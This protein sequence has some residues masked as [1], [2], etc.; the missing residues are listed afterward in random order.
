MANA[1]LQTRDLIKRYGSTTALAG[2]NLTV[3]QGEFIALLGPSGCGKTTLLR[4]IAGFIEPST[5]SINIDGKDITGVPPHHRPVNTVFQNYALFPHMTVRANVGYGP[6]RHGIAKSEIPKRVDDALEMV[7]MEAFADRFP[8]QLSGGQQQRVA[9]ARAIINRPRVLLLD[10][11]L[12][13]L[14]LKLRKR[15]QI[16][17]KSLQKRLGTTFI[18]VTHDQ[19]EAL[20]MADRIAVMRDGH[21]EQIGSGDA[22][23]N[24]PESLFVADFI[25]EANLIDV[26]V[27]QQGQVGIEGIGPIT[28][29]EAS[30]AGRYK[31]LARPEEVAILPSDAPNPDDNEAIILPAMA[32]RSIFIGGAHLLIA[33]LPNGRETMI[34]IPQAGAKLPPMDSSVNLVLPAVPLRLFPAQH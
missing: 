9:L 14:D 17:L 12:G 33:E 24:M 27:D 15:M 6:S 18:F 10:E 32:R 2:I 4:C 5:G 23:Y 29:S 16:E 30:P 25:G 13:A 21:M 19:E 22:I 3:E 1:I 7:G 11:P 20:V 34:R 28:R 8:Q 26:E 31:M